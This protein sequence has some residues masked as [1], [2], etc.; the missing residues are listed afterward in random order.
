M[1]EIILLAT[2]LLVQP[3]CQE[4]LS[5]PQVLQPVEYAVVLRSTTSTEFTVSERMCRNN[6]C[7][8]RPIG[9]YIP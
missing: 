5:C 2:T 7:T 6:V 3:V 1:I 4:G 9:F 8:E